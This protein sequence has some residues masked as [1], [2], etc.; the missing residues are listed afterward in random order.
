[1]KKALSVTTFLSCI[2]ALNAQL[3]IEQLPL[4]PI[5]VNTGFYVYGAN[6]LSHEIP[7]SRINGSP[8]WKDEF[9]SATLFVDDKAYGPCPVKLNLANNELYFL[10]NKGEE[11]AVQHGLVDTIVF[12][13]NNA[14]TI[15]TVFYN[16][17][18]VAELFPKLI[19]YVQELNEGGT[20]LLKFTRKSVRTTDSLF[21]T[22]KRYSFVK[23]ETYLLRQKNKVHRLNRLSKREIEPLL[24]PDPEVK[25]WAE[26]ERINYSSEQNV[27]ELINRMNRKK[28]KGRVL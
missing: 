4:S 27:I 9:V 3:R 12:H 5:K 25:R 18:D 26:V 17:D 20:K 22:Q 15:V 24:N 11:L 6:H 8:F 1:M 23:E 7:Y 19:G 14:N 13:G 10:N 16:D 2:I 28:A 21:G